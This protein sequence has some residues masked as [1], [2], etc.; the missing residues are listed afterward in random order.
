LT[1]IPSAASS[2]ASTPDDDSAPALP[3]RAIVG[4]HPTF[5]ALAASHPDFASLRDAYRPGQES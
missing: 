1:V 5:A 2:A 3:F 4:A